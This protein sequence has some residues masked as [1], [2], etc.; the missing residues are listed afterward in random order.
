MTGQC[1]FHTPP[2]LRLHSLTSSMGQVYLTHFLVSPPSRSR[3]VASRANALTFA[4][5]PSLI[6]A[7]SRGGCLPHYAVDAVSTPSFTVVN[8]AG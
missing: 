3:N 2:R 6:D 8:A 5:P 4:L 1:A 7:S